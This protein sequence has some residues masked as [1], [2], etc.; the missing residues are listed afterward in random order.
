MI[1]TPP[2]RLNVAQSHATAEMAKHVTGITSK[3]F[4]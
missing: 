2:K 3:I 4:A 1:I